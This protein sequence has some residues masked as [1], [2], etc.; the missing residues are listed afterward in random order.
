MKKPPTP[1]A[2]LKSLKQSIAHW[3][4]LATGKRREGE[5]VGVADCALCKLFFYKDCVGCPVAQKVNRIGCSD[6][7]YKEAD[8]TYYFY[9]PDSNE[10]K[11]AAQVELNFLKSL[12]PKK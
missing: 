7:P 8:R 6:T 10:F 11:Q 5:R 2:T 1:A 9:G 12:L 4:R 3:K